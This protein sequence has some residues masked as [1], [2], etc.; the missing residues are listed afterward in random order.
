MFRGFL[1]PG[2]G[3][4]PFTVLRRTG[5]TTANGRPTTTKLTE[6]GKI[7]G[8]ISQASQKEQEQ[9]KQNGHPITH[10]IVQRGESGGVMVTDVLELNVADK[11]PRR[12]LVQGVHN[13][14]E[15][16]HFTSYKVEER[17]DLQ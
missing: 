16:G 3:F 17:D 8:I 7:L 12:F 2:Q 15:L 5:G 9:W 13:P 1:R 11:P 14:A 10:T 4:R 6:Q